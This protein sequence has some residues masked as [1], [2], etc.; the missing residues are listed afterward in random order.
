[1]SI[2]YLRFFGK[3]NCQDFSKKVNNIQEIQ[4]LGKKRKIIEENPRSWQ[5]TKM[6]LKNF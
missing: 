1:M 5:K 3:K 2:T 4:N 6:P